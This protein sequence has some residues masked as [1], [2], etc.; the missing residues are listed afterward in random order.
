MLVQ[1]RQYVDVVFTLIFLDF[2]L[3]VIMQDT[4]S[5]SEANSGEEHT[6][7]EGGAEAAHTINVRGLYNL[8]LSRQA[9]T[10]T[11]LYEQCSIEFGASQ[12]MPFSILCFFLHLLRV[13]VSHKMVYIVGPQ[14]C[15]IVGS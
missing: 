9:L 13:L 6:N 7:A 14:V 12:V 5:E 2:L 3:K 1:E 8:L 15:H 10:N 4:G 11:F